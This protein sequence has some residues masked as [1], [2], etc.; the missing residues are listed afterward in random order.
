MIRS[1]RTNFISC[2]YEKTE[3]PQ[4]ER[5]NVFYGVRAEQKNGD[6]GSLSPDNAEVN[7]LLQQWETV[8]SVGS[9]Q[10]SYLKNKLRYSSVE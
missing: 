7:M 2:C 3:K 4:Q 1:N 9:V 10:R 8:L 6:T 5:E